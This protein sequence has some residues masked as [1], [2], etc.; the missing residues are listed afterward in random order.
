MPNWCNNTI[1]ISGSEENMKPIY[2]FLSKHEDKEHHQDNVMQTLIPHDEEYLRIQESGEFLLNPQT[3]FYGTKWD[4]SLA[5]AYVNDCTPTYIHLGPQ[6]AWSPPIE[7]CSKLAKKYGVEVKIMYSEPGCDFSGYADIDTEGNVDDHEYPYLE[8]I[9]HHFDEE[10]FWNEIGFQMEMEM[11]EDE[12]M[13]LED[14]INQFPY[15]SDKDREEIRRVY[16]ETLNE[17]V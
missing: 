8:G 2:E 11:D 12:P 9:Y 16:L 14:F 15:V 6:T 3:V 4:F 5:E 1:E 17:R 7:F 10:E 13:S